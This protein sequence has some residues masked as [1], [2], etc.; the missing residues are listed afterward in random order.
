MS[1]WKIL[2]SGDIW[3]AVKK[4]FALIEGN[5]VLAD[6]I[7]QFEGAAES[8]ALSDAAVFAP[9]VL[10]GSLSMMD[11]IAKLGADLLAK[12]ISVS[13]VLIGNA[14]RTHLNALQTAPIA[15]PITAPAA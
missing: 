1:F 3:G 6:W 10:A 12:G 9:Q 7:S 8:I 14:I 11:A 4:L 5:P 15:S 2:G 13:E